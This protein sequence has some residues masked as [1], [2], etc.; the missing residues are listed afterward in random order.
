M[1]KRLHGLPAEIA[2]LRDELVEIWGETDHYYFL[3]AAGF[4]CLS[5]LRPAMKAL[6]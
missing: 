5:S 3:V 2:A 6:K 4:L 1:P